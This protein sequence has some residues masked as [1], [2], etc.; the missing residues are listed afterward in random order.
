MNLSIAR[1]NFKI[2]KIPEVEVLEK[3]NGTYRKRDN[4]EMSA[5]REL[6]D[7]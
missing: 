6:F 7:S 1:L 2:Q 3:R 4:G 5:G